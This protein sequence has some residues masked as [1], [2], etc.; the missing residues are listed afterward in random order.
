MVGLTVAAK[1]FGTGK[2]VQSISCFYFRFVLLP[3]HSLSL[4]IFLY[5]SALTHAQCCP[6]TRRQHDHTH[7]TLTQTHKWMNAT[8]RR[9]RLNFYRIYFVRFVILVVYFRFKLS[10]WTSMLGPKFPIQRKINFSGIFHPFC[11]LIIF[12]V[13]STLSIYIFHSFYRCV[14]QMGSHVCTQSHENFCFSNFIFLF[15]FPFFT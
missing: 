6:T 11:V 5:S 7:F 10:L 12:V 8:I 9:R 3:P 4:F 1:S 2:R 14:R 13:L 15:C